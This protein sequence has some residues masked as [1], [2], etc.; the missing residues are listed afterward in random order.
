MKINISLP[1]TLKGKQLK[2][3]FTQCYNS[4]HLLCQSNKNSFQMLHTWK[5]VRQ[6]SHWR[7][8][9]VLANLTRHVSKGQMWSA[10]LVGIYA[11]LCWMCYVGCVVL[12]VLC[13]WCVCDVMCCNVLY[14]DVCVMCCVVLVVLCF[15]ALCCALWCYVLL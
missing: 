6:T 12:D 7:N 10:A 4:I 11:V 15:I 14:C 1:I 5:E 2:W 8:Q 3:Y 9:H 13:V